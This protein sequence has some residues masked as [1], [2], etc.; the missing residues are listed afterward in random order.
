ML[1]VLSSSAYAVVYSNNLRELLGSLTGLKDQYN[2]NIE[3]VPNWAKSLLEEEKFNLTFIMEDS[4]AINIGIILKDGKIVDMRQGR[5]KKP[6]VS[7][8]VTEKEFTQLMEVK[9]YQTRLKLVQTLYDT[10][11]INY[12][13]TSLRSKIK[14][15]TASKALGVYNSVTGEDG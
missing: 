1:L 12:V 5:L 8:I 7:V 11:K 3:K 4:S 9:G 10:N 15:G 6:T 14:F 13:F 2:A